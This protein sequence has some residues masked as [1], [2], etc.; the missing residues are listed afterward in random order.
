MPADPAPPGFVGYKRS[1]MG[2][3]T[4]PRPIPFNVFFDPRG[5]ATVDPV[6]KSIFDDVYAA[7]VASHPGPADPSTDP[8]LAAAFNEK[9]QAQFNFT[10]KDAPALHCEF[11]GS[12][13]RDVY[14]AL[15]FAHVQCD[16]SGFWGFACDVLNFV[17]SIF[18]GLPKLIA[19]A[20]PGRTPMTA[21]YRTLMVRR[22]RH[23]VGRFA[24]GARP[25]GL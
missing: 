13:I 9:V 10:K 12:R 15:D 4:F 21:A 8:A 2:S 14:D 22:R 24:R 20:A 7:Y 6:F 5:M 16:T 11:E 18:L 19:A 25:M 17:L 3:A 1:M 23:Q